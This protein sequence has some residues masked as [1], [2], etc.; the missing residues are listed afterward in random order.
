M[1][2]KADGVE[3]STSEK[4]VA[5]RGRVVIVIDEVY[6][7]MQLY[8]FDAM[9]KVDTL[10]RQVR[11][12]GALLTATQN[13]SDIPDKLR[14]QFGSKFTYNTDSESDLTAIR[15]IDP[16]YAW[17]AKELDPFQFI[18]LTF[19]VGNG[20][21]FPVFK[22]DLVELPEREVEYDE[23]A[24]IIRPQQAA[25]VD[26]G[27]IIKQ[28]LDNGDVVWTSRLATF[29]E[30]KYHIDKD[31]AKL[32]IKDTFQNLL[33]ANEVQ[34]MRYDDA[35]SGETVALYFAKC[36][37]EKVSSLHKYMAGKL[38]SKLKENQETILDAAEAG[39][40]L[41]DVETGTAY[42]EIETGL[43]TRAADLEERIS[44]LS[45]VKPFIVL[46]P[47][48]DVAKSGRYSA[49]K[50]NPRV[51]VATLAEFLNGK[52]KTPK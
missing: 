29:L 49:L 26:Y 43:K 22:A 18:D 30:E 11:H 50:K 35:G 6:R 13:Y 46:V 8:E 34:V 47:N 39:Q 20:G 2:Q 19:R 7:L 28:K 16:G 36:E 15:A 12:Y 44:R 31:I 3:E 5:S 51:I 33:N 42:F 52:V 32:K 41:P 21:I 10:M 23:P 45:A 27:A 38:V 37:S 1:I 17:M 9:S 24:D 4:A 25:T 14:N 48:P 40:S